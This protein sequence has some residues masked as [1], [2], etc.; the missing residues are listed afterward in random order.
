MRI[1][2]KGRDDGNVYY[3][4]IYV[5]ELLWLHHLM[6][7]SIAYSVELE[8]FGSSKCDLKLF[9]YYLLAATNCSCLSI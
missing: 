3:G 9:F 8:F 2:F 7:S 1:Y 5:I 6:L 4:N